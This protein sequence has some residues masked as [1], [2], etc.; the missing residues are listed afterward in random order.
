MTTKSTAAEPALPRFDFGKF[1]VDAI[2]A[3]QKANMETMVTAQKI[4][5]DLAQT[6]ARRQS[7]MLKENF[8][9]SEKLFQ[10]FDASRQPTD[11]MDEARSAMEKAL[12]DVQETVDL[13]M[14]AQNEVVDLF[15]QR[16]SKNFEEVKAF[17]A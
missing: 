7:E 12:A 13:G 5:F 9:R 15:V 14:K 6:V 17:A 11:Y 4:L 8:T 2:V 16:A 1:D 3:L 10:S